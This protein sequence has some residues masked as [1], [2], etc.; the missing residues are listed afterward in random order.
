MSEIHQSI[1]QL[2]KKLDISIRALRFYEEK[3]L[4]NPNFIEGQRRYS[5]RDELRLR[6]IMYLKK[7]GFSL[8]E[9][10]EILDEC[11]SET[12]PEEIPRFIKERIQEQLFRYKCQRKKLDGIITNLEGAL[13]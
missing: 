4:I 1:G 2:S 8:S 7:F 9:I 5:S 11:P 12:N 6:Q 3:L 10:G 13:L